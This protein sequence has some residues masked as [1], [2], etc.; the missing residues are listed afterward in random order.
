MKK[1]IIPTCLI[2]VLASLV[3]F[4]VAREYLLKRRQ[5]TLDKINKNKASVS[6]EIN[7]SDS[8]EENESERLSAS[9]TVILMGRNIENK[10]L[11]FRNIE[12]GDEKTLTFNGRTNFYSKS[13]Q[14]LTVDEL[15]V[16]EIFDISFSTYNAEITDIK[17]SEKVWTNKSIK[18]FDLNDKAYTIRIGDELFE[19]K[20]DI[21]VA[22]GDTISKLI[23][24]T[25]M[26]AITVYG[27]DNKIYSIKIDDG[28]GYIRIKNDSYFVGGWIEI[29]QEMIKVLTEDM[30]IPVPEGK[31]DIKVTNKGYAGRETITVTRD[32][33]T[34]LDLSNVD[35]EEVAIGHVE[36]KI[37]PVY[38]QLYVD[39]LRTDYEER[40]P[41]EY[42]IHSIRAEASGY[43]TVSTNIK[44]GSEY[45]SIEIELD[46]ATESDESDENNS[47][48][49]SSSS[50]SSSTDSL[51]TTDN[52]N[53]AN[54]ASDSSSTS[55]ANNNILSDNKKIFVEGPEG[56]EIYVDGSYI[57]VAPCSTNKVTGTHTITLSKEGYQTKAYT[58]NVENDNNDLT[59][60]FSELISE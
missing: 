59:L 6:E 24:I 36:F 10:E 31:Y 42:G 37:K 52:T 18:K 11:T 5:N 32:K 4:L 19:L 54:S 34:I 27:I 41:L 56:A 55:T 25:N 60:S 39:G 3:C 33:E 57:G 47:A 43:E 48:S 46:D 7:S 44:V 50:S 1:T 21:V 17:Q 49:S 12:G 15:N 14:P 53:T 35:I 2:L 29:G 9:A 58:V 26:D 8:D 30:L 22:S 13:G 20:K 16:G 23:D 40:I 28:H 45:A 38:A 51:N